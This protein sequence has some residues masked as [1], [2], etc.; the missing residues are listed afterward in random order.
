MG[1]TNDINFEEMA[2]KD[3]NVHREEEKT[4]VMKV[5]KKPVEVEA[6]QWKGNNLSEVG[7]FVTNGQLY[8]E[9]SAYDSFVVHLSIQTLEGKMTVNE[10]DWIIRG[11]KGEY[12]PCKPDIFEETYEIVGEAE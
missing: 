6:I 3:L 10:G 1:M 5:R 11:V 9:S 2:T 7:P 8:V 4:G 12:Y